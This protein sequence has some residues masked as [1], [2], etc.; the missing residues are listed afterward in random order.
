MERILK[1]ER[2]VEGG[3]K[4][5]LLRYT[6]VSNGFPTEEGEG[7]YYGI[8]AEQFVWTDEG[9]R[10]EAQDTAQ[11]KGFSESLEE[12]MAFFEKMVQG[13]VMPV[14]LNEIVDDWKSAFYVGSKESA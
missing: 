3:C 2:R 10:W 7:I 13:E 4:R 6:L 8:I 11:V 1:N 14:S 9:E 12:S 5:Y